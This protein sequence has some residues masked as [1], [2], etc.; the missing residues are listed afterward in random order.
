[1]STGIT[2]LAKKCIV[3]VQD[4]V[5]SVAAFT[6]KTVFNVYDIDELVASAAT[7]PVTGVGVVYEGMRSVPEINR[8]SN[9]Q[10]LSAEMIVAVVLAYKPEPIGPSSQRITAVDTLD[11]IRDVMRARRSPSGHLWRFY[12]EAAAAKRGDR[13]IWIQRWATPCILT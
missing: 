6:G 10:G 2:Q 8:E 12:I 3:D 5:K 13:V 9:R 11:A 4:A 1:M 7:L